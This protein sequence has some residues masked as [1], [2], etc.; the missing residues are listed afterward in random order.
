MA[1][2]TILR[3]ERGRPKACTTDEPFAMRGAAL[4]EFVRL[5][6]TGKNVRF[7]FNGVCPVEVTTRGLA[8]GGCI[9]RFERDGMVCS[10]RTKEINALTW[11]CHYYRVLGLALVRQRLNNPDT[12]RQIRDEVNHKW[13]YNRRSALPEQRNGNAVVSGVILPRC[14]PV[15][16]SGLD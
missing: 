15:G 14:E 13:L 7:S 6:S 2:P 4:T 9:L 3:P 12:A 10:C 5:R 1:E 16:V 8:T 11:E